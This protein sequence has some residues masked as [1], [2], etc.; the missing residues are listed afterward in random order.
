LI[1]LI[2]LLKVITTAIDSSYVDP[3]ID[4]PNKIMNISFGYDYEGFS[5][6]VSMLYRTDVFTKTDFW[7]ELRESTDDYNRF[8][9]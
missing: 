9:K 1:F 6:S 4:Q 2:D 3:L 5:G 7:P 8:I